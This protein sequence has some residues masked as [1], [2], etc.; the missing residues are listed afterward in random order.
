MLVYW[1]A[2]AL[3]ILFASGIKYDREGKFS[4]KAILVAFPFSI[5]SALRYNV[6]TDYFAYILEFQKINYINGYHSRMEPLFVLLNKSIGALGLSSQWI[7]IITAFLFCTIVIYTIMRD[8]EL[9]KF[10]IFL[11]LGAGFY[12]FS[13]N[14]IRQTLA[15]AITFCA[16]R[17]IREKKF[18][19]FLICILIASG[20]H[21]TA[22]AMIPI[23]FLQYVKVD[24]KKSLFIILCVFLLKDKIIDLYSHFLYSLDYYNSY[25]VYQKTSLDIWLYINIAI[26]IF[27]LLFLNRED[28]KNRIYFYCQLSVV[29][30]GLFNGQIALLSRLMWT[31]CFP[32]L[33]ALPKA[34]NTIRDSKTRSLVKL[35]MIILF[36]FYI[37]YSVVISGSNA[38]NP[39]RL[40]FFQ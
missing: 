5:I 6:G 7:F 35:G 32:Q 27:L 11:F 23:Y 14:G 30:L 9:P 16:M 38:V 4:K 24:I 20:F 39:Y 29:C 22:L 3:T 19:S 21:Y 1:F 2:L 37:N 8:S 15:C 33:V 31:F 13:M 40:I 36:A 25:L 17:Y 28:E 10:S 18:V 26:F 12:T 34:I